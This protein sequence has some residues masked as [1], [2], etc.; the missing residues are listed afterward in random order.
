MGNRFL[1]QFYLPKFNF[2]LASIEMEIEQPSQYIPS[3]RTL[4]FEKRKSND[5]STG[6]LGKPK[7][8][9]TKTPIPTQNGEP[10][11]ESLSNFERDFTPSPPR[12]VFTPTQRSPSRRQRT[13]TPTQRSPSRRQ[14]TS[15]P[16][17][18]PPSRRQR[19]PTPTQLRE[20]TS[21]PEEAPTS[22]TEVANSQ[23]TKRVPTTKTI[24][25]RHPF[26]QTVNSC[27]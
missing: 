14:R 16:T 8:P 15:T 11:P 12:R 22:T 17:Q 13:P 20:R 24:I 5:R 18:R 26:D 2:F 10:Q 21:A 25:S 9:R 6:W 4:R 7:E 1:A 27:R 3:G 23:A 19:T